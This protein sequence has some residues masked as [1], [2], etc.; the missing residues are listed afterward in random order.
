MRH[1]KGLGTTAGCTVRLMEAC[2]S[3]KGIKEG[4]WFGSILTV[5]ELSIVMQGEQNHGFYP[6]I[7]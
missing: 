6:R 2:S 7:R 3:W 4:A 1:N 5:L